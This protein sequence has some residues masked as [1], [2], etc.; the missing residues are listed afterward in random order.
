MV[1]SPNFSQQLTTKCLQSATGEHR[2]LVGE[3]NHRAKQL[4]TST[5]HTFRAFLL[6]LKYVCGTSSSSFR[7]DPTK[8]ISINIQWKFCRTAGIL[9]S[10]TKLFT[11]TSTA[12]MLTALSRRMTDVTAAQPM[13]LFGLLFFFARFLNAESKSPN[14]GVYRHLLYIIVY[15]LIANS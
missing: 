10:V 1:V 15:D 6:L 11:M 4:T 7:I 8:K 14:S 5:T 2:S 12:A 9:Q 3:V 13:R